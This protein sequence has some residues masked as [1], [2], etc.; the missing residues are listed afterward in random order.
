MEFWLLPDVPRQFKFW[1]DE[2]KKPRTCPACAAGIP[3]VKKPKP[4]ETGGEDEVS[5]QGRK[6]GAHPVG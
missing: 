2:L 1:L 6:F 5:A 4:K 3:L